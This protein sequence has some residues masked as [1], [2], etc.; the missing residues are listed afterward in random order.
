MT[1]RL[2][3]TLL[4]AK[5]IFEPIQSNEVGLIYLWTYGLQLRPYR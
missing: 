4:R 1:V 5:E 3:N 2:Y